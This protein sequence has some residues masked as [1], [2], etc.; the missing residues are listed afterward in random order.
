MKV[1]Y[2]VL[3]LA[4]TFVCT[5]SAKA[6]WCTKEIRETMNAGRVQENTEDIIEHS[7]EAADRKAACTVYPKLQATTN[8]ALT[9]LTD[10]GTINAEQKAKYMAIQEKKRKKFTQLCKEEL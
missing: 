1:K 6:W 8:K 7:P 10:C 5:H 4:F 9:K 2:V 3:T